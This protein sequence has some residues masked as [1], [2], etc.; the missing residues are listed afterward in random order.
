M[1]FK[2][3]YRMGIFVSF[4]K[5]IIQSIKKGFINKSNNI[6]NEQYVFDIEI[7]VQC[8]QKFT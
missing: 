5:S 1:S 7:D 8:T 3:H 2:K 4:R 6:I